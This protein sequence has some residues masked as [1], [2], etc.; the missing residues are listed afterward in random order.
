[1]L[2]GV[3]QNGMTLTGVGS[4]VQEMVGGVVLLLAVVLAAIGA[5]RKQRG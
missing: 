4:F 3:L 1:M 2:I 5:K